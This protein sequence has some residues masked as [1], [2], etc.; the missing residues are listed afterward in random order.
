MSS[1]PKNQ[2]EESA[3][4]TREQFDAEMNALYDEFADLYTRYREARKAREGERADLLR[5]LCRINM[6]S[7]RALM[8]I[9]PVETADR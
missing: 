2:K 5:Y 7:W 9:E 6:D 4:M 8:N 3:A 1:R